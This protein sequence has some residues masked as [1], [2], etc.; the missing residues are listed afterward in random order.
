[1]DEW[2]SHHLPL[3]DDS[4]LRTS[5]TTSLA[6]SVVAASRQCVTID[7]RGLGPALKAQAQA[8]DLSVSEVVRLA[9]VSV[10]EA[11]DPRATVVFGCENEATPNR[12]V[13]LSLRLRHG[14]VSRLTNRA[15]ECGVSRGAFLTS[16]IDGVP[17]PPLAVVNVLGRSTDQLAVVSTDLNELIRTIRR[18]YTFSDP[19]IEDRL[20]PLLSDVRQHVSL[21]S[22]LMSELRPKSYASQQRAGQSEGKEGP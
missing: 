13:K 9:V 7:L 1:M 12:T 16:L 18:N 4:D 20:R 2:S 8:R 6:H 10:L 19:C 5:S 22:H 14:V 3:I 21:A 15:R 11:S 17:V